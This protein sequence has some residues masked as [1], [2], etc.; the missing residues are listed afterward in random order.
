TPFGKS[1]TGLR[2]ERMK[3]SPRWVDGAFRNLNPIQPR[4]KTG[5]PMPPIREFLGG[6]ERR[7]PAAALPSVD[8]RDSWAKRAESGLRA[9]WLGHSTVLVEI[10]GFRVLTAPVWGERASPV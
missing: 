3:A 7:R 8:P 6:G 10:D 1:A 2:L 5:V 9:T 4:L